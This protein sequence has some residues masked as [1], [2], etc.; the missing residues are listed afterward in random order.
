MNSDDTA[1][2]NSRWA[3]AEDLVA[4]VSDDGLPRRRFRAWIFVVVLL[5]LAVTA[6]VIFAL[7]ITPRVA[8]SSAPGASE[9]QLIGQLVFTALGAVV[10]VGGFIW[11][12][13]KGYYITRWRHAASPLT[14]EEKRTA[15]RQIAGKEQ[16]DEHLPT[17]VGIAKQDRRAA[18]G[19][20]PIYGAMALFAVA[21]AI[22]TDLL[23]IKLA[24][25]AVVALFVVVGLQL[26]VVY[27][28]AGRFVNANSTQQLAS[29]LP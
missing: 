4:G 12:R 1:A 18:L 19:V 27:H 9:Q 2:A 8:D 22:S 14:R 21:T 13:R 29:P 15:R 24:E 26:I 23:V 28:R 16:S 25:I 20:A 6:G 10:G 5:I 17:V 11:A 7:L 3:A